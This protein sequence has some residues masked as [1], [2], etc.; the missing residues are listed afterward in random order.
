MAGK[1]VWTS[2]YRASPEDSVQE[3][4][5]FFKKRW[6]PMLFGQ[7]LNESAR[8]SSWGWI[9]PYSTTVKMFCW[10]ILQ[11]M[12][13]WKW[14]R[15]PSAEGFEGAEIGRTCP[16][17]YRSLVTRCEKKPSGNLVIWNN[18]ELHTLPGVEL[19]KSLEKWFFHA[20]ISHS[21]NI[22]EESKQGIRPLVFS[23]CSRSAWSLAQIA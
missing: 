2:S 15:M 20:I 12:R 4:S 10:S 3:L 9:D 17:P 23:S 18:L 16:Y 22:W 14:F 8:S 19:R 6:T 11:G 1:C 13:L 21:R 7:N 5:D